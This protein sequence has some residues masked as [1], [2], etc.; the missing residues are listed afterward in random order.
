M[1]RARG[2][3]E[4]EEVGKVPSTLGGRNKMTND[5]TRKQMLKHQINGRDKYP[6]V[7]DLGA[8]RWLS[9]VVV[10]TLSCTTASS[11]EPETSAGAWAPPRDA[12]QWAWGTAQ[13]MPFSRSLPGFQWAPC[14]ARER[15]LNKAG[16]TSR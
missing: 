5:S 4:D 14:F 10:P 9:E 7:N 12:T 3:G 15:G 11:K 2:Q 16:L 1:P 6:R 8:P 13:P